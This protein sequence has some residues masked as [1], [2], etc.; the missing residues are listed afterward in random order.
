M[1]WMG[2]VDIKLGAAS[3]S[4]SWRNCIS[5]Y[6]APSRDRNLWSRKHE[7]VQGWHESFTIRIVEGFVRAEMWMAGA[8]CS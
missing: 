5:T 2:Y 7:R 4:C 6:S 1:S 3:A 8:S